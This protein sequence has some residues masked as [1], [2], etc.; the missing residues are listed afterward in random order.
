MVMVAGLFM[1]GFLNLLRQ[2]CGLGHAIQ[3]ISLSMHVSTLA[4]MT[5]PVIKTVQ[6]VDSPTAWENCTYCT[7]KV[8]FAC[9]RQV[10]GT[11]LTRTQQ[12]DG[13]AVSVSMGLCLQASRRMSEHD[14]IAV[15]TGRGALIK[16]W[17]FQEFKEQR[18]LNPSTLER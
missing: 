8:M 4:E 7:Y 15:M 5:H 12:G 14:C 2:V 3:C 16:P 11:V 6:T 13:S 9:G 18:E 17:L 1:Q 10:A